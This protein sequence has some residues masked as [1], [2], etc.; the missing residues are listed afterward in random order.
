ME[1]VWLKHYEKGVPPT[2]DVPEKT[3][4]E[5]LVDAAASFPDTPAVS[6]FGKKITF[7][8][9]KDYVDH[10]AAAL[11]N[12]GVRKGTKVA[13]ILPNLPQY[14]IVHFAALKLGAVLV[15]TNPL[16]VE[17]EIQYQLNDS[18]AEYLVVLNLLFPRVQK[19]WKETGLKRV[20]VT[21]VKEYLP[22]L[23]KLLYPLKEKKEG[24]YVKVEP[25]ENVYFFQDLMKTSYPEPEDQN[26]TPEDIAI[27]MYTGGTTGVSKG[28]VL[29]HRNIVA[30]V[31]QTKAWLTDLTEGQER[32]LSALPFFHSYGMTTCLH[33]SVAG[34]CT[35]V[36]VPRFDTKMVLKAIQK[37]KVTIF[38]GVPTMYV[39]INNYPDVSKYNI[40]T[41]KACIS[42]GAAL[43]VEVQREF[44]RITGGRLVEGYGLSEASPVTHANP[45]YGL[46]KEGSIGVPFPSTDAKIVDPET[47]KE[48]PVGEIGEL[49]VSGP[50]IMKEYWN[51]PDETSQVLHDGW[52]YTG[53]MAKMDED[54][55]FYIVDRKKDLII[56][57]GFNIYP[58]EVE[59]VLFQ[60]PKVKEAAVAGV[61][62]PYRGETVKAYIVL[63]D[64]ETATEEEIIEF[65]KERLAKFKVPKIVEFRDDLPKSLIGKVLRR[66]LVEEDKKKMEEARKAKGEQNG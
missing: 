5:L 50:Q 20:I 41:I 31:L 40:R 24:T 38:P 62:D 18:N 44:E 17:R 7:R 57:G 15:P 52:L 4:Y 47:L 35:A 26:V 21:G 23:L 55:Y 28:A 48:L 2:I 65:C 49:A 63:K 43:P 10:F 11:Y 58:R 27:F 33:L 59:E 1:K 12:M 61:P 34:K 45:I 6:F 3:M 39:A 54:G 30:N 25:Q 32:I 36:L 60:H 22:G 51:K 42:G 13:I 14:P 56:A 64:G 37:E 19:I 9:L 16:Y 8:Q 46:R 29:T 53:D 66:V